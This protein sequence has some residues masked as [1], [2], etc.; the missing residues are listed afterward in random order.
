MKHLG[1]KRIETER[2]ILRQF[3]M[4]D[5]PAMYQNWASD[6][7]V[8]RFLTWPP[9]AGIEITKTVL[10]EWVSSYDETKYQWCIALKE[11]NEAIGSMGVTHV[12]ESAASME[13]GYCIGRSYWHNGITSEALMAVM[14]Y[15][16]EEVGVNRIEARHNI[17]NP[18]SGKV[19]KKCGLLY[20][21]TQRSAFRDNT[22]ISDYALYGYVK[23]YMPK[24]TVTAK[25]LDAAKEPAAAKESATEKEPAAAKESATEKES[26]TTEEPVTIHEMQADSNMITDEIIEYVGILAKLELS[27]TEKEQAKKDMSKMLAYV[28]KLNE[29][30]TGNVEPMSHI[31]PITNVFREDIVSDTDGSEDALAN[32]PE[33]KDGGFKVPK[34]I[35]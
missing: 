29:L 26:A 32:A 7:E 12:D 1:T 11:T 13:L 23:N 22:G 10:F 2:L 20:E 14:N 4:E 35:G 17:K 16:L 18:N 15:L 33:K 24:E 25:E 21:G 8:T 31:F 5:A 3:T 28:D 6:P 19:L 34:T 30:D 9:H 27:D